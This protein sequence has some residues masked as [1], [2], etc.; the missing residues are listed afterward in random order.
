MGQSTAETFA[1]AWHIV[2]PLFTQVMGGQGVGF[3]DMLVPLDRDGFL[4]ECYFV[5]TYTPVRDESGGVGGLLVACTETTARVLAERR[6]EALRRLALA[7]ARAKHQHEAWQNADAV[8]AADGPDLPFALLYVLDSDEDGARLIASAVVTAGDRIASRS[9]MTTVVGRSGAWPTP[10]S[11][12]LSTMWR[13]GWVRT[14]VRH[15][16]TGPRGDDRADYETGTGAA[17]WVSRRRRQSAA[18]AGRQVPRFPVA[19]RRPDRDRRRQRAGVRGGEAADRRRSSSSIG[20]RRRSS[21]M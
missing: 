21:A 16:R 5:Y 11:R 13:N 10:V 7:V 3:T 19:G 20:R 18:G 14:R 4:E 15:G 6:L 12:R 17:V 9:R 8:L 1:E 2:G